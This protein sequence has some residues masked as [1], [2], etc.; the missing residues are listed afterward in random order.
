MAASTATLCAPVCL[1]S[2]HRLHAV[3]A[4]AV[5][6]AVVVVVVGRFL[7]FA[8]SF[9]VGQLVVFLP[10]HA[11][12]LE[13]H[14]HLPFGQAERVGHLDAAAAREIAAEVKL[15]LEL[16]DLLSR[17][18]RPQPLWLR[19]HVIWINCKN[20]EQRFTDRFK[21]ILFILQ[22]LFCFVFRNDEDGPG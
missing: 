21:F 1:D 9:G 17:V 13:P 15:L 18:G 10:A 20:K 14:L 4:V 12:V 8:L 6:V 16:Q 2:Y 22:L 7:V 19:A 11:P 5:A 3:A